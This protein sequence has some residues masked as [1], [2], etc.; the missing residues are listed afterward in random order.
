[1]LGLSNDITV[2]NLVALTLR[3]EDLTNGKLFD[4]NTLVFLF[5]LHDIFEMF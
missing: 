5:V 4:K 1:M 3:P 2:V